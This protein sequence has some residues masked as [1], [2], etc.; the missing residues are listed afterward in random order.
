MSQSPEPVWEPVGKPLSQYPIAPPCCQRAHE[1]GY[2]RGYRRGYWYA[3]WDLGALIP[4][5]DTLWQQ[6][7]TFVSQTLATWGW[8]AQTGQKVPREPG[9]RLAQ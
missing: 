3:L 4:I 9:P 6:V 7:E 2:R 8:R 5:K 1:E